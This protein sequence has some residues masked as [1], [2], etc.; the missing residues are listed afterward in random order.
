MKLIN[1]LLTILLITLLSSPSW[2]TP[3]D[4]LVKRDS[5]IYPKFSDVPFTGEVTG[6]AQGNLKNGKS[7]GDWLGYH[8]NGNLHFKGKYKDG[9]KE[10]LWVSYHDNGQLTGK[11]NYKND[12]KDGDWV[13][14]YNNGLLRSKGNYKNG[15]IEGIYFS[16]DELGR[17]FKDNYK[18]GVHVLTIR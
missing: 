1:T 9:K 2:S 17:E 3:F 15:K 8:D 14:Y 6:K 10:G 4:E 13:L 18:D 11:G 7:E 5:L 16:Y 12:K